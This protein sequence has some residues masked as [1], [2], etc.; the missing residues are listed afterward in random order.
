[1]FGYERSELLGLPSH[2]LYPGG[3]EERAAR[4][5]QFRAAGQMSNYEI[6]YRRKDG[7]LVRAIQ[8]IAIV[9]DESGRE[10][11]EGTVVDVTERHNLE[12]QLR[13]SQKMEAIGRLAGG[14][15]HDFNNLLTVIKGYSEL[16]I[17][18]YA[19]ADPRRAEVEE[20]RKAADRAGSLTRQLLA[21]SR[22]Q[23]LA[24]KTLNLNQAVQSMD[25]LLRRLLGESIELSALLGEGV[26]QVRADPGQ[27]EQV[28]MNLAINARD[29]MPRGG[30]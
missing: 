8:N 29:A 16:L 1:M 23:V 21:F 22:Q 26:G 4:I 10:V 5:R 7:R 12:E 2:V 25:G 9:K 27:L 24:P 14:V 15:A 11:T 28:L 17:D 18:G 13:Q 6:T 20:I 19:E 30:K 3:P